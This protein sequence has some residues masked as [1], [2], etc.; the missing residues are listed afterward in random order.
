VKLKP[1][2]RR[3]RA[4][5]DVLEAAEYYVAQEAPQAALDFIDEL[6]AALTH[7]QKNP[8]PGSPRYAH[9]L[10]LPGLRSWSCKRFPY[11]VFYF[12]QADCI[13]VWR[14]LHGKRDIPVWLQDDS[15]RS[16]ERS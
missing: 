14:V 12:E 1:I 10:N 16:I 8:G 4:E 6:E 9:S 11:L 15:I 5:Q 7:I 3:T 13:D 2:I